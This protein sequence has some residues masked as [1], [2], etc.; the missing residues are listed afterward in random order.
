ARL[1][2]DDVD[3]RVMSR[4]GLGSRP[5]PGR[6]SGYVNVYGND[7]A[8]PSSW[9]GELN[10]DLDRASLVDIPLLDELHRSLCSTHGVVFAAGAL[11]GAIADR[12][13]P[14]QHL[15]LVGPLAQVHAT[16]TMDFDGRLNLEVVVNNH[17][18]VYQ[19]GQAMMARAPDV[20]DEVARR[21]AQIDQ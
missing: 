6:L 20:A 7:P 15:T 18:G 13:V 16:G 21:A 11:R 17:R 4:E 5:V 2:V 8:N 19:S 14:T 1:I 9:R 12:G 10:F 3:L